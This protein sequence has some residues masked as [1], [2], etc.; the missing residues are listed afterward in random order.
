MASTVTLPLQAPETRYTRVGDADIAYQ[1]VGDGPLDLLYCRGTQHL[2]VLWE[3]PVSADFLR[4]LASFSRLILFDRRGW[5]ASDP[6]PDGA[7]PTWEGWAD[8]IGAVL[9]AVGSEKAALFGEM[10]AG[11][12]SVL[13]AASH[14]ERIRALILGNTSARELVDDDYPIGHA[15]EF[16]DSMVELLEQAWGSPELIGMSLPSR[17]DDHE[18]LRWAARVRRA[19]ATPRSA[20]AQYRY[21]WESMDVR[22]ALPL[23][24]VPTLVLH[25]IGNRMVP[26]E[27]GRFLADHI[28]GSRAVELESDDAFFYAHRPQPVI[29]EIAR[30]LT[31]E[32]P[33]VD[34]DR[35]LTTVLFTDIVGSTEHAAD[36][37]DRRWRSLL[38]GHDAVVRTVIDQHRGR[39]VKLT[40]DGVL[41]T[42][43]G[44]GRGIRCARA[45]RQALEPLG[46]RIR[47][48]L[49]S[50]EVELRGEDIGGIGVHVAARVMGHAGPGELLAS[51]AVP[52]LVAGSGIE[53]E[54]RGE[55]ALKG[56][57]GR[58]HLFA[59]T[60]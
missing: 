47:A 60:R 49:H 37:G 3:H 12:I 57:P 50:G 9:D 20:A 33:P 54:D 51:G 26:I 56:V 34:V 5:G 28:V 32:S 2:E 21:M 46:L 58:W 35:V 52:P 23:I 27:H 15:A 19:S 41:A 39:L 44:P 6:F 40:G 43:D 24:Q 59:V 18:F 36:V 13:Y 45:V 10:D 25:N 42:F 38:D 4:G 7:M 8:D 22:S 14:P 53:F 30:F 31:G 11:P 55:H 29:D 16:L 48:G 17:A 1:V